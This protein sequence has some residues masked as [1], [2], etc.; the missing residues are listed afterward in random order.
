MRLP[1]I[2]ARVY[3]AW[4]RRNVDLR[5]R[6]PWKPELDRW[7]RS[8]IRSAYHQHAWYGDLDGLRTE[9]RSTRWEGLSLIY[10]A[11]EELTGWRVRLIAAPRGFKVPGHVRAKFVDP[12]TMEFRPGGVGAGSEL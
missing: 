8:F 1:R 10:D 2:S 4:Y 6:D 3:I 9:R 7:V 11:T 12:S 5:Q